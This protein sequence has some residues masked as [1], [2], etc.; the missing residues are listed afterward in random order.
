MRI[1][2]E[3][4][5]KGVVRK[6]ITGTRS[7]HRKIISITMDEEPKAPDEKGVWVINGNYVTEEAGKEQFTA[8]VTSRGEVLLTIPTKTQDTS[9]KPP[10]ETTKRRFQS[11]LKR[12]KAT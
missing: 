10:S 12:N 4:D 6:Y 1:G 11:S 3:A 9:G 8:S 5:A 2:N 7:R